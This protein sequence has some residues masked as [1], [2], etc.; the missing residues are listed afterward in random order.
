[1]SHFCSEKLAAQG[2]KGGM[3]HMHGDGAKF[4]RMQTET[5]TAVA[6]VKKELGSYFKSNN[7]ARQ[8]WA[9][10]LTAEAEQKSGVKATK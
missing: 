5:S 3:I 2:R 8:T 1:M 10:Q 9:A 7:E 6:D 4:T